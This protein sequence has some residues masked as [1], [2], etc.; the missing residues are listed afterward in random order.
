MN[1]KPLIIILVVLVA[2]AGILVYTS[3]KKSVQNLPVVQCTTEAMICPDGTSVGR[4]G[5]Y[6][7]FAKCP[8][9]P[10]Q[11]PVAF[12]EAVFDAPVVFRI[13]DQFRYPT[14]LTVTLKKIDDSRCPQGVQCI[15]AGEL[16]PTFSFDSEIGE[17]QEVKLGTV[18][19]KKV[20]KNNGYLTFTL[21]D[22]TKTTATLIIHWA[23]SCYVGGCSAQIC[24]DKKDAMS[25][26]EFT[27]VYACYQKTSTCERQASGQCGWTET[28][29]LKACLANPE[30][31]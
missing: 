1:T 6:C 30:A 22:A 26:C 8:S 25:T 4:T 21:K 17:T 3:N 9:A 29:A 24:S 10:V 14:G 16:A 20:T 12:K 18:N 15:W 11:S 23:Q 5:L 28:S 19:N 13:N 2:L 27:P 31:Y 7:E